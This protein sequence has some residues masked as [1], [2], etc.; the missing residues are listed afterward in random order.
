[1]L[2]DVFEKIVPLSLCDMNFHKEKQLNFSCI[3]GLSNAKQTIIETIIWPS[4]VS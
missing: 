3:G 1:M 4:K 2:D